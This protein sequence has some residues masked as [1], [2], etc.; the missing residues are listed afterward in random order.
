VPESLE[1]DARLRERV[2]LALQAYSNA[3]PA[4][5]YRYWAFSADARVR[6][7]YVD[8]P[9]PG[10]VRVTV[11]AEAPGPA[12]LD[13]LAAVNMAVQAPDVRVLTDLV[14]VQAATEMPFT[15]NA[16]LTITSGGTGPVLA[17]AR[18]SLDAYL[19]S[20]RGLG[21]RVSRSG[22]LAALHVEGVLTILMSSPAADVA[23]APTEFVTC[24]DIALAPNLP[25]GFG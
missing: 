3:G 1:P 5:A 7:V 14:T 23:P 16:L 4:G 11:M 12:P 15:V 2:R 10:E 9:D 24:T 22:I 18:A 19:E 17:A 25:V 20:R 21:L 13:L 8:S 6:D